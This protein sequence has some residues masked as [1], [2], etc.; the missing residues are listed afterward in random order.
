[1]EDAENIFIDLQYSLLEIDLAWSVD[2]S[3]LPRAY[4]A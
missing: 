1:M 3:I 2:R 4:V